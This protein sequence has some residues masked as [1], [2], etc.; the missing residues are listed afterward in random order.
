MLKADKENLSKINC[1]SFGKFSAVG[2]H[3]RVSL[4]VGGSDRGGH[5]H[6]GSPVMR[7]PVLVQGGREGSLAGDLSVDRALTV[8]TAGNSPT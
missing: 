4:S 7:V 3:G 6:G 8:A 1:F 5:E 2:G